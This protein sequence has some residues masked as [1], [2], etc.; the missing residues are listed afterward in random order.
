[1]HTDNTNESGLAPQS[2]KAVVD[3]IDAAAAERI[4]QGAMWEIL[5]LL[6]APPDLRDL[7]IVLTNLS[8][9]LAVAEAQ[10][11]G[12]LDWQGLNQLPMFLP[13]LLP[14]AVRTLGSGEIDRDWL[15]RNA[16]YCAL[17]CDLARKQ[18]L[19]ERYLLLQAHFFFAHTE[20]L[21]SHTTQT[22]YAT[23]GGTDEWPVLTISP[24]YA[25]LCIRDMAERSHSVWASELLNKLPV[26]L[27]PREL[28]FSS[29]VGMTA[30]MQGF[31]VQKKVNY[32][33]DY[34]C[35]VYDVKSRG[36]G[37]GSSPRFTWA[38]P[39]EIGD[40]EDPSLNFGILADWE[41]ASLIFDFPVHPLVV[42]GSIQPDGHVAPPP[43][44]GA[45]PSDPDDDEDQNVDTDEYPGE[46]DDQEFSGSLDCEEEQFEK[47]PGSFQGRVHCYANQVVRQQKMFRF[48]IER[49]CGGDLAGLGPTVFERIRSL[50]IQAKNKDTGPNAVR[51]RAETSL[52]KSEEG[53]AL[54]FL[55]L[56]FWTGSTPERVV[57]LFVQGA[58]RPKD[59]GHEIGF[60]FVYDFEFQSWTFRSAVPFPTYKSSQTVGPKL[61]CKR[62]QYIS[63]PNYVGFEDGIFALVG[64]HRHGKDFRLFCRPLEHYKAVVRT[65]LK[66][67]DPSGRITLNKISSTLFA[68]VMSL[69]G[70]DAVA[71]TMITGKRHRLSKVPMYYAC[72]SMANIWEIYRA[73]VND[74]LS[75]IGK[76][77]NFGYKIESFWRPRPSDA[78]L[79]AGA[80]EWRQTEL[81]SRMDALKSIHIGAR[82]CPS[83]GAF[84]DAVLT[85]KAS[86]GKPYKP[87]PDEVW[88]DFH[89][90]FTFYSVWLF[91][92][93]VGSRKLITPYID[94]ETVSPLNGVA[95]Y[96]DKD[97]DAGTKA[98]LIWLPKLVRKQMQHYADHLDYIRM[99]FHI[100]DEELPCFFLDASGRPRLVRPK[101]MFQYVDQYFPGFPVDI[102]RR[103]MFNALLEA[104]C[105]PEVARVWMGHAC[106][107]E[108]WWADNATYSHSR[109]RDHLLAYLVPILVKELTFEL[110][111]GAVVEEEALHV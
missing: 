78:E 87:S 57:S 6:N 5:W 41:A 49:L 70:N 27:S 81:T 72:R 47:N 65:L 26:T 88:I 91:N 109:H 30:T 111:R 98:K 102:H 8:D 94:I 4:D 74:L 16:L 43:N 103:F 22:D 62:T 95:V 7:P 45:Q 106:A 39:S 38:L 14:I 29:V 1:V 23:Y 3:L 48:A 10:W 97:G 13:L 105:P 73:T 9:M 50:R 11:P 67:W 80:Y 15:R 60:A 75:E 36:H 44:P 92:I 55:N 31:D 69:S 58:R 110:I 32:V 79:M 54:L 77:N 17:R 64:D 20:F 108:E 37:R 96:R 71:A 28:P 18:N 34:L 61:D 63:L 84:H 53:E 90:R 40:P 24:Y 33:S 107:G 56:M 100:G 101:S 19:R 66:C 89:N 42:P 46:D 82:A 76:E 86:L 21:R 51:R 99:R 68:R 35:Q 93:A 85:L 59:L 2:S 104:G 52:S 25:G 83:M 12:I